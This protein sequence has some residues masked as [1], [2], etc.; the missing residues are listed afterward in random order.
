M[1]YGWDKDGGFVVVD[2]YEVLSAYAYPSS[3]F[4]VASKRDA[5][6][7]AER[8]IHE[9]F[10]FAPESIRQDHYLRCCV[11]LDRIKASHR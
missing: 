4:A 2:D 6:K 8:M 11:I 9:S 3:G 1:R 7:T 10:R 5:H